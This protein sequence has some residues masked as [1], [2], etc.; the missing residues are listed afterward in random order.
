M[1]LKYLGFITVFILLLFTACKV[2]ED[3]IIKAGTYGLNQNESS[4]D[5]F[6]AIKI[7]GSE[8]IFSYDLLSSYM[9]HGIY[10]VKKDLIIMTTDDKEYEYVFQIED[11][12]LIF[13][14]EKSTT[15]TLTGSMSGV[16]I[17]DK[18]VFKF[19]KE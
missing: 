11:D 1:K 17:E 7:K 5:V 12:K 18:S 8:F 10:K 15:V 2:N 9:P 3:E 6:S 16:Q 14:K 13:L 4:I 19:I